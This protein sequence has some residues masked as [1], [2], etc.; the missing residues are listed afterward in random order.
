MFKVRRVHL[1]ARPHATGG[2]HR[3]HATGGHGESPP[4]AAAGPRIRRLAARGV[5][6]LVTAAA[7]TAG[8]L[9]AMPGAQASGFAYWHPNG[10]QANVFYIGAGQQ[11]YNWYWTGSTWANGPLG[12]GMFAQQGT[13]LSADWHPNGIQANVFYTGANGQIYNWYWTGST[14]TNGPLGS[15]EAAAPGT[16]LAAVWNPDR[17]HVNVFYTGANGQM[18]NWWWTGGTWA[19]SAL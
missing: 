6:V 7:I 9:A 8:T 1:P 3:W 18:Y 14:W 11:I 19:N 15:G 16:G 5:T 17:V 10:T 2:G 12:S 13:G 4:G